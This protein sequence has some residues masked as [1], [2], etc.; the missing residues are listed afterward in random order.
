MSFIDHIR[1]CNRFDPAHFRPFEAA[2]KQ[3]GGVRTAFAGRLAAF[4]DLFTVKDDRVILSDRFADAESRGRAMATAAERLVQAGALP[5][6]RGEDYAVATA[7]GEETLFRLDRA[8]VSAFGVKAYGVH[9]NGFVR[10][11]DRLR[12]WIGRRAP[13][14]P[15]DPDKL[16][17]MVA[18]GQPAGL[19]LLENVVKES[20][21]EAGMAA[22][23]A[24]QA[25]PVGALSYCMEG[26]LGLKPDTLFIY[27]LEL[28][29]DFVPRNTDGEITSFALMDV[30]EV[31]AR[32]RDSGDFKFNVPLVLI[33]FMI[34]HGI[35][36]AENEPD[37]LALVTGLRVP[38]PF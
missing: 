38:H 27:D 3:V 12:L 1:R 28:A 37:Y 10:D 16:D 31:A 21:E 29:P 35:L 36:T 30:E 11:G 15:V 2:G 18:G 8:Y 13:N 24:R 34:R 7:W 25:R 14:K 5:P 4:P 33:D 23:L 19:G 6:P 20:A 17:N 26:D 32:V 9:V 22:D